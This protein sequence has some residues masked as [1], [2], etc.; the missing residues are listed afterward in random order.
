MELDTHANTTVLGKNCLIIQDFN[1]TVAVSGW[2]T[3]TG[4]TNCL[5]AM[6][7]DAYDHPVSGQT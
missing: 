2:D 7:L 4:T 3:S 5:T 1:Q 6:R